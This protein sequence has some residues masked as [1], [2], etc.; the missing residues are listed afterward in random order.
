MWFIVF[1]LEYFQICLSE[2]QG[3]KKRWADISAQSEIYSISLHSSGISHSLQSWRCANFLFKMVTIL[4]KVTQSNAWS[5]IYSPQF[6]L[7]F[8]KCAL[9]VT[10]ITYKSCYKFWAQNSGH[11]ISWSKKFKIF[12][13]WSAGP[14]FLRDFQEMLARNLAS[15]YGGQLQSVSLCHTDRQ[16]PDI[17][18]LLEV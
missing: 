11:K 13:L 15:E 12:F 7:R 10:E 17:W 18:N 16:F 5:K 9:V 2:F 4:M 8:W 3:F 14:I 1:F 6:S